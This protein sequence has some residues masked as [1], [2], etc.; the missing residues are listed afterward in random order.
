VSDFDDLLEANRAFARDF[1][2]GGLEAP[3]RAGVA[4]VTCLDSPIDPLRMLGLGL[5]DAKVVRN[6][7]ARV[8]PPVLEAV[9]LAVHLLGVHRVM[10]VPHTRC[11]MTSAT[12]AELRERIGG[13]V[14]ADITWQSFGVVDDQAGRLSEDVRAVRSHPLVPDSVAVGGFLYDV[15]TGL[16]TP[17]P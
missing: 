11:A 16:L 7:G 8:T 1:D 14:G 15:D 2:E 4:V 5:G 12:E 9:V 17:Q 13:A 6:P 3:A 10:V